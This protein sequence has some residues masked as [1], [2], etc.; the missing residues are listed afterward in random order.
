MRK[1]SI[2]EDDSFTTDGLENDMHKRQL[3]PFAVTLA[4]GGGRVVMP[5][6]VTQ[7]YGRLEK[8]S[9]M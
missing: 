5:S 7:K 1:G 3:L 8:K 2:A 4:L 6:P 9:E